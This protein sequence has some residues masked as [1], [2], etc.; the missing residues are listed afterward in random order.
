MFMKFST[1]HQEAENALT[2]TVVALLYSRG[3][4]FITI[5]MSK[6]KDKG[7]VGCC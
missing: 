4:Q 6:G 7:K 3:Q 5:L 1:E 2:G